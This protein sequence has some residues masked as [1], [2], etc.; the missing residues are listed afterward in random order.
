MSNLTSFSVLVRVRVQRDSIVD[1]MLPWHPADP[2]SIPG[3]LH[4]LLSTSR[5]DSESRARKPL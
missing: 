5:S 4:S 3:F 1:E 2:G